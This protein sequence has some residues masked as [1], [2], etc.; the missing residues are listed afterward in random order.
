MNKGMRGREY[1][2]QQKVCHLPKQ[3]SVVWSRFTLK[4][5]LVTRSA[6]QNTEPTSALEGK[7]TI[8]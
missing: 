7:I 1:I 2:E 6:T 4:A 3:N 8:L 5:K